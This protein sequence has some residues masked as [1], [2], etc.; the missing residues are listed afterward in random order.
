MAPSKSFTP[1]PLTGQT[2]V[3]ILTHDPKASQS[4]IAFSLLTPHCFYVNS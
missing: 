1:L 3:A 2:A 4:E